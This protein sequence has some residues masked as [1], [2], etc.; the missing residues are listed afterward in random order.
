[1][2]RRAIVTGANTGIGKAAAVALAREGIE[3][4]MACRNR[5]RGESARAEIVEATGNSTVQLMTVDLASLESIADFA[6]EFTRRFDRLDILFNNAGITLTSRQTSV[7]GNEMVF[8]VN[9]LGPFLLTNLL[10]ETLKSTPAARIV[11]VASSVHKNARLNSD[12]LQMEEGWD[13]RN[14]YACSKYLNILFTYELS[15]RNHRSGITANCFNPGLVRSQFF[16]DYHPV[17][18][19]LRVVLKLIGRSPERGAQT[20]VCLA[21]SPELEGKSGKYYEDGKEIES[22][23]GTYDPDLA[24]KIWAY[25]ESLVAEYL[26]PSGPATR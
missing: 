24:A 14:A 3:V 15:R 18:F 4:I 8:A 22:A 7:D 17:P 10:L 11:N 13:G 20:G 16:R 19:M 12:D 5:E 2:A 21:T 26:T 1:M 23:P 25:S 6:G 9:H